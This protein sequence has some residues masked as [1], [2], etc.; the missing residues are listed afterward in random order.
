MVSSTKQAS[1]SS[2]W[3]AIDW[4]YD[5]QDMDTCSK[6]ADSNVN[7]YLKID[8]FESYTVKRVSL[9]QVSSKQQCDM[10]KSKKLHGAKVF[11]DH[12]PIRNYYL[13][14]VTGYQPIREFP[15]WLIRKY[16]SQEILFT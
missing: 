4:Y 2:A 9:F 16:C 5:G 1:G 7:N 12:R 14:H 11:R 8:L 10:F 6:E 15:D 13:G 3:A